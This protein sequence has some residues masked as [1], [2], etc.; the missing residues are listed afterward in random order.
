MPQISPAQ[1]LSGPRQPKT[2][3]IQ[4]NNY[5]GEKQ[6]TIQCAAQYHTV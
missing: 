5:R 3:T 1:N 6:K 2:K 4:I